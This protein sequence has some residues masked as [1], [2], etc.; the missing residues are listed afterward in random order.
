MV[1]VTTFFWT[2]LHC[3][4]YHLQNNDDDNHQNNDDDNRH[5]NDD[6]DRHDN[7]DDDRHDNDED[8]RHDNDDDDRHDNDDG[9]CA[10]IP[11]QPQFVSPLP[12]CR[13][14][15]AIVERLMV[16]RI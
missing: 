2:L 5:D 16:N 14:A 15:I 12:R 1:L 3:D 11:V 7:D 6:D 10:A 4:P 8:H 9:C 13:V